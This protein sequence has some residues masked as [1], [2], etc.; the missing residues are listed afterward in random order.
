MNFR[1][2]TLTAVALMM[3]GTPVH[4]ASNLLLIVDSSNSM[5]GQ[6]DGKSKMETART[7]LTKLVTDLPADTK[8]ALMAYGH[9]KEKD[10]NDIELLS[11]IGK[12]T[13]DML[14]KLI[15]SLTPTGKTPIAGALEKSKAAFAGLEGQNN[16]IVLISDGLESC[17]GDPCAVATSLKE[18]GIKA[19]A[20]VIGFGV[21]EDEGKQLGCIAE[22]S[23]GKYFD[24]SDTASFNDAVTEV[25][26][27]AQAEPAPAPA[28]EPAPEPVKEPEASLYF[29][30]DFDSEEL[31]T[32]WD[33][34]NPNPDQFIVEDGN[35]LLIGKSVGSL[36]TPAIS[37]IFKL[38]KELPKGDWVAT[39]ELRAE[40]QT[41][42]DQFSFGLYDDDKNYIVGNFFSQ[43][44][45]CCYNSGLFLETLK[46]AGGETTKFSRELLDR[47]T[48][49]F[50]EYVKTIPGG[51]KMTFKLVKKDRTYRA[52]ASIDGHKDANG[53]PVWTETDLVTS[54]R[55]PKTF[56]FNASQNRETDG[57]TNYQI[58]SV[59]IEE[60]K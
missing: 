17:D 25:T 58:D 12:D 30:D 38:T 39:V 9:T 4:A 33:V 42:R 6:V 52:M 19:R 22:N 46:V 53:K 60:M 49:D 24:A 11:A 21:S 45:V 10:C 16:N 59:K 34:A 15:G 57:E 31:S 18:A 5:W 7:T 50:M 44:D 28:P 20:H 47:G 41:G 23:G 43:K 13:P 54:L 40:L 48:S 27:L 26:Q 51:G 1:N 35:L 56:I 32:D 8:L 14:S 36:S 29:S 37:N 2:V 3:L 55:S